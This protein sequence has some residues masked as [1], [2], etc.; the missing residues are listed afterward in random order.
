[1]NP[2]AIA[3]AC[4][5]I[6][7]IAP[8]VGVDTRNS[9]NQDF[10]IPLQASRLVTTTT[11]TMTNN[12]RSVLLL[13]LFL[14]SLCS[15]LGC[16]STRQELADALRGYLQN[17]TNYERIE[18]WCVSG[19][20]IDPDDLSS[21]QHEAEVNLDIDLSEAWGRA[22]TCEDDIDASNSTLSGEFLEDMQD[23]EVDLQEELQDDWMAKEEQ[24]DDRQDA[25]TL[26]PTREVAS[27]TASATEVGT[28]TSESF[29]KPSSNSKDMPMIYRLMPIKLL[30]VLLILSVIL[31]IRQMVD[32]HS[33]QGI[34][35]SSDHTKHVEFELLQLAEE[36]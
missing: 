33:Y 20:I 5:R 36:A 1:V 6:I 21:L 22:C 4:V 31:A 7:S 19:G 8:F 18:T 28:P 11:T 26:V 35:P 14:A 13:F 27:D 10:C 32:F 3:V 2:V 9:N 23:E 30:A 12:H 24:E 15:A 34:D 25:E 17:S 16:F 29:S